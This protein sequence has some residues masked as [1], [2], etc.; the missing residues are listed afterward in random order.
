[1]FVS[2]NVIG[3]ATSSR[4]LSKIMIYLFVKLFGKW[5]ARGYKVIGLKNKSFAQ[6]G[7]CLFRQK[8]EAKTGEASARAISCGKPVQERFSAFF[9]WESTF[10]GD[11]IFS[12]V[13][14]TR[15]F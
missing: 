11:F 9:E 7:F 5:S 15:L 13:V 14:C 3:P 4:L 10:P 12:I 1:M 6:T 2:N 8:Q